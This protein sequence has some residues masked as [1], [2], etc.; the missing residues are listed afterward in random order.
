MR[1]R[2]MVDEQDRIAKRA[3]RGARVVRGGGVARVG[4]GGDEEARLVKR[5]AENPF[6]FFSFE[7]IGRLFGFSSVAVGHLSAAGAPV[8][9]RRMNPGMLIRWMAEHPEAASR[10]LGVAG[11]KMRNAERG[12]RNEDGAGGCGEVTSY[13]ATGVGRAGG[14]SHVLCKS[15]LGDSASH[16]RGGTAP[17]GG[18]ASYPR[19]LSSP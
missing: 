5:A 3:G 14:G 16:S 15:G 8:W 13:S 4:G 1:D 18:P 10:K 6:A 19:G 11:G 2:R 17:G 12:M 9:F 7:E